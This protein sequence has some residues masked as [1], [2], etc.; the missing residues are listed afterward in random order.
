MVPAPSDASMHGA[1][2]AVW[3]TVAGD[4]LLVLQLGDA[5]ATKVLQRIN[6]RTLDLLAGQGT[7]QQITLLPVNEN[8][9]PSSLSVGAKQTLSATQVLQP[10]N[11][12]E[13]LVVLGSALETTGGPSPLLEQSAENSIG[14]AAAPAP[15]MVPGAGGDSSLYSEGIRPFRVTVALFFSIANATNPV[16]RSVAM[17]EGEM[18]RARAVDSLLWL[19][20]RHTPHVSKADG[21]G[22]VTTGQT[23]SV[24]PVYRSWSGAQSGLVPWQ[25]IMDCTQVQQFVTT[26]FTS[27]ARSRMVTTVPL[28]LMGSVLGEPLTNATMSMVL[29]WPQQVRHARYAAWWMPP[30]WSSRAQVTCASVQLHSNAVGSLG[31]HMLTQSMAS[32]ATRSALCTVSAPR[33]CHVLGLSLATGY[34]S[35]MCLAHAWHACA[36]GFSPSREGLPLTVSE[37]AQGITPICGESPRAH[38]G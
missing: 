2:G 1:G 7:M 10:Q 3:Y 38:V 31:Q 18:V 13:T 23:D 37:G 33:E 16:A 30:P 28:Q 34:P 24:L 29:A 27:A 12:P 22:Q 11:E 17:F 32:A 21:Q 4:Q 26:G 5:S 9:G 20:L 19:T 36:A 35:R 25:R 6:L 8:Q 15:S 14:A